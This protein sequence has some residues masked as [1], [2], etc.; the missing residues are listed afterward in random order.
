M[1]YPLAV[2]RMSAGDPVLAGVVDRWGPPP[3]WRH[4]H[5]FAGLVQGIL[6]QQVSLESAVAAFGKLEAV[7]GQVE[8]EAFLT[9]DDAERRPRPRRRGRGAVGPADPAWLERL[10]AS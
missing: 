9:L 4:A 5:G 10:L 7:L 2:K 6:A 3:F 8:P 1:T